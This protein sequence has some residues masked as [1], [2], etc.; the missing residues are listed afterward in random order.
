M[1][2]DRLDQ[3]VTAKSL[4]VYKEKKTREIN[5]YRYIELTNNSYCNDLVGILIFKIFLHLA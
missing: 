1:Q 5:R 2:C 4:K 3:R